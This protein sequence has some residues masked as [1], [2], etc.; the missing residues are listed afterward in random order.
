MARI[1]SRQPLPAP[2]PYAPLD[3]NQAHHDRS[4]RKP[5][6]V[7]FGKWVDAHPDPA[8]QAITSEELQRTSR[9][10]DELPDVTPDMF[11][12][13]EEYDQWVDEES[14]RFFA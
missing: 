13:P 14:R 12:S 10:G 9:Y 1:K 7:G 4:H 6:Q 8:A 2:M 5:I 11:D 3:R